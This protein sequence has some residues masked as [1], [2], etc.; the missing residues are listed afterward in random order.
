MLIHDVVREINAFAALN[1]ARRQVE[2]V[3]PS[4]GRSL[5]LG[6]TVESVGLFSLQEVDKDLAVRWA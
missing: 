2:L 1:K 4:T 6:G 5:P 3:Q